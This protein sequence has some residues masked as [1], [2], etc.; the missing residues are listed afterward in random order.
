MS[1]R[2]GQDAVNHGHVHARGRHLPRQHAGLIY[3][4]GE[5]ICPASRLAQLWEELPPFS[6][7]HNKEGEM[8]GLRVIGARA[9]VHMETHITKPGGKAFEG[10][11]C[12][13]S[14]NGKASYRVY[15]AKKGA[16][17]DP[18]RQN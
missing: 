4:H 15:S 16:V 18:W 6:K 2:A 10:M 14:P 5:S 9:S 3:L 12:G 8:A 7:I 11:L 1:E 17:C 13:S